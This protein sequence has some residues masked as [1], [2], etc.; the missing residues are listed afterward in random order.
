MIEYTDIVTNETGAIE[1]WKKDESQ[2][3]TSDE[4]L[5]FINA[6]VNESVF[7]SNMMDILMKIIIESLTSK[8]KEDEEVF[9]A[10]NDMLLEMSKLAEELKRME[11]KNE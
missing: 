7:A 6:R 1:L 4:F 10:L 11:S 9:K 5:D 3:F 2:V 8:L